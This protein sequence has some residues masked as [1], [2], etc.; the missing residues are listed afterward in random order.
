MRR[1]RNQKGFTIMELMIVIV[2]IGIL[3]AIAI[4]AYNNFIATAQKR[5]CQSNMRTI[6]S[7]DGL[8]Y[9]EKNGH[10]AAVADLAPYM[11]N[12]ASI[13]CPGGGTYTLAAGVVTCP[14]A[15]HGTMP[16]TPPPTP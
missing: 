7:A 13:T 1:T 4:P 8:Y 15:D 12:A 10:A 16:P 9:A 5:A 2:I 14:I 6:L 11:V 3:I